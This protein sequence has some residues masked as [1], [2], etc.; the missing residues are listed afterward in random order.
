MELLGRKTLIQAWMHLPVGMWVPAWDGFAQGE[1]A[2]AGLARGAAQALRRGTDGTPEPG[3]GAQQHP[4]GWVG[5]WEA[6]VPE[7]RPGM[8]HPRVGSAPEH[9]LGKG[10]AGGLPLSPQ[11]ATCVMSPSL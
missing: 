1:L 9:S 4:Q 6:M 10:P 3:E 11:G 8:A 5:V 7:S 2:L